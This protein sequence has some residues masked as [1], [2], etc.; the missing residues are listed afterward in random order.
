MSTRPEAPHVSSAGFTVLE[1]LVALAILGTALAALYGLQQSTSRAALAVERAQ[2]RIAIE[3]RA[4]AYLKGVNPMLQPEGS[5]DLGEGVRLRWQSEP[6]EEPRRVVSALGAPGRFLSQLHRV[7]VDLEMA[8][9]TA[10]SW[11]V[12]LLGWRPSQPFQP[13][14]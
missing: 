5:A 9:G 6:L 4:L 14:G 1:L 11:E 3:Q 2:E 13:G 7:R 10:R 12:E 8:E